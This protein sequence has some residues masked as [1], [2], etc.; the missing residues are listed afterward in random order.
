LLSRGV[1]AEELLRRGLKRFPDDFWINFRLAQSI[2]RQTATENNPLKRRLRLEDAIS[3]VRAALARR[4]DSTA[5][6]ELLGRLL[7]DCRRFDAAED[8]F[9]QVLRQRASH[10][11]TAYQGLAEVR[12]RRGNL[13]GAENICREAL[14]QARSLPQLHEQLGMILLQQGRLQAA[15]E[16]FRQGLTDARGL[17]V[18]VQ[19]RSPLTGR[20]YLGLGLALLRQGRLDEA[21]RACREALLRLPQWQ[22]ARQL[23]ALTEAL[24][25]LEANPGQ[26]LAQGSF[27]QRSSAELLLAAELSLARRNPELSL[28]LFEQAFAR[29]DLSP[30]G[31]SQLFSPLSWRSGAARAAVLAARGPAGTNSTAAPE[32]AARFHKALCW[33]GQ[34]LAEMQ[35]PGSGKQPDEE[36]NRVICAVWLHH[37]D[38]AETRG[39]GLPRDLPEEEQRSWQSFW[40]EVQ[41]VLE[42]EPQP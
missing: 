31:S 5:A 11:M 24:V 25:R 20:A 8:A 29:G 27:Q 26:A 23:L 19:E 39:P 14:P 33:L 36:R 7:M 12:S 38:L 32:R 17:T 35:A 30:A 3:H 10:Q 18:L 6:Q 16:A 1:P 22:E 34:D 2:A 21:R 13:Q 28:R 37:P 9:R 42:Q 15:E 40:K 41:S 4:R